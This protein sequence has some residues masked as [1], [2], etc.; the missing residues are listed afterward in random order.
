MSIV[1][2][3]IYPRLVM[4]ITTFS[5]GIIS[6]IEISSSSKPILVLLSSPNF[7]AIVVISSLITPR[8]IFLSPRIAFNSPIS[9]TSSLCCSSIFSDSKPVRVFSL[10]STIAWDCASDKP[11]LSINFSLASGVLAELRIMLITSSILSRAIS[12]P[13]KI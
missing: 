8:R 13:C 1:I 12:R 7:S 6:S 9:L 5:S 11:N 2:L 3:L 4:A 10:I